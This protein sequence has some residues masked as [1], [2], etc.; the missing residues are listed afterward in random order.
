MMFPNKL[1]GSILSVLIRDDSPMIHCND[2]S[3]F[4]SVQIKLTEEQLELIAL[5]ATG[6]TSGNPIYESISKCWIEL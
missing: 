1:P 4:R 2:S 3:Q 5:R 6:S